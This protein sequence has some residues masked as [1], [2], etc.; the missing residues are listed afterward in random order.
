[1]I[2]IGNL[3]LP[4]DLIWDNEYDNIRVIAARERTL[5]GENVTFM[6]QVQDGLNID[7][8]AYSDSGWMT[9]EQVDAL[10]SMSQDVNAVYELIYHTATFNVRFRFEDAPVIETTKLIKVAGI[11]ETDLFIGR[12]KLKEV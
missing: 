10:Y 11:N 1:M 5:T 12:I 7:L 9:R 3:I 8:V 2:K 6:Q 4:S